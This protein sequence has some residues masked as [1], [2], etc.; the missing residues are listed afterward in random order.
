MH[1]ENIIHRDIK[2]ENILLDKD[3]HIKLTDFGL[4]KIL[5][6]NKTYTWC[7]TPGYMSPEVY[8]RKGHDTTADW[9]SVGCLMFKMLEGRFPFKTRFK[10]EIKINYKQ[11]IVFEKINVKDE[12]GKN[13]KDLILK[14]LVK[15]PE[16]R[17]GA[18]ENG[19][20]DI[21]SI[22]FSKELIGV[23]QRIKN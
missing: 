17:L 19:I 20:N 14:F 21:K 11:P 6:D 3:G 7:G 1:N 22:I 16:N 8:S 10:N 9:W 12:D 5:T 13:A 23:W 18:G 4:S 2:P 15:E